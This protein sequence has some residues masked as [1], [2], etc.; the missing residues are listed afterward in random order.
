MSVVQIS[1]TPVGDPSLQLALNDALAV[2]H[3]LKIRVSYRHSNGRVYI[4]QP[5]SRLDQ[6]FY[7][8][9]ELDSRFDLGECA[10]YPAKTCC[11]LTLRDQ[12]KAWCKTCYARLNIMKVEDAKFEGPG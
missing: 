12:H 9:G 7:D 4:L 3:Q 1:L 8:I 11:A 6:V 2:A 10:W 5:Y